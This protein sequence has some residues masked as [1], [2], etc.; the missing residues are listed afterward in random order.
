MS[1]KRARLL[2]APV[3]ARRKRGSGCLPASN[4]RTR[5]RMGSLAA[6]A[7]WR[8]ASAT[9][10][11]VDLVWVVSP[12]YPKNA[13]VV[14]FYLLETV[15]EAL[16]II[17]HDNNLAVG[18]ADEFPGVGRSRIAPGLVIDALGQLA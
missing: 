5:G 1:S 3:S 8:G 14:R 13:A 12:F 2:P 11:V 15:V 7:R 16:Q 10:D 9:P 6:G 4:V 18:D 17:R